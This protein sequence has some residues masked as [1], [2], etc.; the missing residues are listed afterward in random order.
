M[1]HEFFPVL[2]LAE[3]FAELS[4]SR[5]LEMLTNRSE[6]TSIVIQLCG[7]NTLLP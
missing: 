1:P 5:Q 2:T 7:G 6:W 3:G 4:L